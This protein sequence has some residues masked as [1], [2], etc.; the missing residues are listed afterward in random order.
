[1]ASL[2]YLFEDTSC[3]IGSQIRVGVLVVLDEVQEL[4]VES[5]GQDFLVHPWAVK[6]ESSVLEIL[7]DKLLDATTIISMLAS[8]MAQL[9]FL[10]TASCCGWDFKP[11]VASNQDLG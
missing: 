10:S 2:Q 5:G 8:Q 11:Y 9:G 4:L 7:A 6:I 3:F 1:M